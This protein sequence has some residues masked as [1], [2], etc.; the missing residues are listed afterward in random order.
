MSVHELGH[1]STTVS[2]TIRVEDVL[3]S[4]LGELQLLL[5]LLL[6]LLHFLLLL[7]ISSGISSLGL[8]GL[9]LSLF[10]GE[11]GF[12]GGKGGFDLLLLLLEF[13]GLFFGFG[14][15][16]L[17]SGFLFFEFTLELFVH[18][19]TLRSE[20]SDEVDLTG[21]G[22]LVIEIKP[23]LNVVIKHEG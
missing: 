21:R 5:Q 6:L 17:K 4:G 14:E 15:L 3:L 20:V 22:V 16:F 12:L 7:L 19:T 9:K 8:S 18:V 2:R 13:G 1:L 23:I 11:F 10:L